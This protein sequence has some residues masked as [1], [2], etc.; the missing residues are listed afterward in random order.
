MAILFFPLRGIPPFE[1]QQLIDSYLF[2]MNSSNVLYRLSFN[3]LPYRDWNYT[4]FYD[5]SQ[6]I[7]DGVFP[8][9][10]GFRFVRQFPSSAS[11]L[12]R[13]LESI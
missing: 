10:I 7:K 11:C 3:F 6:N 9:S 12:F 13:S 4:L 5:P 2:R 8:N 1:I